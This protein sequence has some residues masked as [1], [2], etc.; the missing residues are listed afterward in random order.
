M[1]IGFSCS[2]LRADMLKCGLE[3]AGKIADST[4]TAASEGALYD[5]V[6]AL[7]ENIFDTE[8]ERDAALKTVRKAFESGETNAGLLK[9]Y[10]YEIAAGIQPG[11]KGGWKAFELAPQPVKW[12]GFV[13][14]EKD[15]PAGKIKSSWKYGADGK[16]MWEFE[17]PEGAKATVCVNG[18]C[19]RYTAGKYTLE[20]K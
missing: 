14:A 15:I 3:G 19:R 5:A 18:V 6:E 7:R 16:C 1:A 20:I 9:K 17:I 13:D 11:L 2:V 10:L 12:L 8:A 4:A